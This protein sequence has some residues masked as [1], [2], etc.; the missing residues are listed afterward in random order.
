MGNTR[1]ISNDYMGKPY[2]TIKV[3]EDL[4]EIIKKKLGNEVIWDYDEDA[5]VLFI[6]KKPVSYTDAL[7]GL[8]S[9]MWESAGGVKDL[10]Q[11]RNSW[12]D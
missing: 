6:I 10:E 11:E 7:A 3:A 5:G 4:V 1:K 2:K 8:G 12:Q 9:N